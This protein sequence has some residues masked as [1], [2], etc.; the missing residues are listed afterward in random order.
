[1][2]SFV[3][4]WILWI[5]FCCATLVFC[6]LLILTGLFVFRFSVGLYCL[7]LLDCRCCLVFIC[8][9]EVA[10]AWVWV[11]MLRAWWISGLRCAFGLLACF[12]GLLGWF[13]VL[14]CLAWLSVSPIL[15][16]SLHSVFWCLT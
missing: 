3:L 5:W 1:M 15:L 2:D 8:C 6:C 7:W 9:S 10:F 14:F 11:V 13:D 4:I 12:F 16:D